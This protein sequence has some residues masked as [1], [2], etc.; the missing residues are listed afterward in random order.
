MRK[1]LLGRR[2]SSRMI[3]VAFALIA[4][5]V[6][7]DGKYYPEKA[8][9]VS[10]AIPSQSAILIYRDGI[11]KLIIQ[12]ALEAQGQKF[13]WIIPLPS[14]PTEFEEATPWVLKRGRS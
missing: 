6:L 11:E 9:K 3:F 4:G 14:K 13:A 8:Y 2:F 5:T 10:P 7:A 12:S 1:I